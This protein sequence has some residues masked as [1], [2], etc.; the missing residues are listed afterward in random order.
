MTEAGPVDLIDDDADDVDNVLPPPPEGA[1]FST[2]LADTPPPLQMVPALSRLRLKHI[3]HT[4]F[5]CLKPLPPTLVPLPCTLPCTLPGPAHL[6]LPCPALSHPASPC[7]VL[8]ACLF[9]PHPQ[10]P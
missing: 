5:V 3:L 10:T 6:A 2:C 8:H 1:P 9:P 4:F 7:P